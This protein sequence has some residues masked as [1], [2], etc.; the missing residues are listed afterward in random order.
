[1]YVLTWSWYGHTLFWIQHVFVL[2][3]ISFHRTLIL[4][5]VLRHYCEKRPKHNI[6]LNFLSWIT[7]TCINSFDGIF[8]HLVC[9]F[10]WM[11]FVDFSFIIKLNVFC[12]NIV[13]E[14]NLQLATSRFWNTFFWFQPLLVRLISYDILTKNFNQNI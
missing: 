3:A 1:M 5:D 6:R 4:F 9:V 2:A 13:D 11:L 10:L 14:N 7:D 8:Y 12:V